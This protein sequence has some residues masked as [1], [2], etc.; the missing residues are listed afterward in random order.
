MVSLSI[1]ITIQKL[2]TSKFT[3]KPSK[4]PIFTAA[5]Q[6]KRLTELSLAQKV[7]Q[8][9]SRIYLSRWI[10]N[11]SCTRHQVPTQMMPHKRGPHL[12]LLIK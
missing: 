4:V 8:S 11:L 6:I 3:T 5:F 9:H 2:C 7:S 1:V 12:E 10:M